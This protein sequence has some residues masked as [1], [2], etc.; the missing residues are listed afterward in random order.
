VPIDPNIISQLNIQPN[1]AQIL[2]QGVALRG[3]MQQQQM[4]DLEMQQQRLALQAQ[5]QLTQAWATPGVITFDPSGNPQVHED[6]LF[7]HLPPTA[8]PGT[9][10]NFAKMKKSLADLQEQQGKVQALHD[11]LNGS[12]GATIK[13]SG[14]DPQVFLQQIRAAQV[15]GSLDSDTANKMAMAAAD[16]GPEAIQHVTDN[17]LIARSAQQR[18]VRAEEE[19]AGARQ[20]TAQTGAVKAATELP[21]IQ[22]DTAIKQAVA[23][24]MKNG[25]T[26]EQQQAAAQRAAELA[27]QRGHLAVAQQR[28]AMDAAAPDLTPQGLDSVAQL[29]HD[30][31]Q[32]VP[33]GMGKKAAE[34]RARIINRSAEMPGPDSLASAKANFTA[35]QASLVA[36]QKQRDAVVAFENTANANLDRFLTT[37]KG[38][39]D[40][41]SP[42][43]N[44]PLRAAAG[45]AF[46]SANKAAF[47]AA[48]LVAQNEIA[49]VTSN[50]NLTGQ[51][52][53]AARR[54]VEA[55]MGPN[56]TLKQ[57]Y[58]VA[59][60]LRADMGARHTALDAQIKAIQDRIKQKP[61]ETAPAGAP[62]ATGTTGLTYQDYL[63]A[64]GG[65]P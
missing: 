40:S 29:F 52:S 62:P 10:E 16:G 49:K 3:Q 60:V 51:L 44:A 57:I 58:S 46:G 27:I 63:K 33:M 64:K 8:I 14:Y 59:Q 38:V 7:S 48:R 23:A 17:L 65:K 30:T 32:M 21:G 12:I 35:N 4:R 6:V 42:M 11:D 2:S 37:A 19:T 5:Q 26:P 41:G 9:L 53:D 43:L 25:L 24:G 45:S 18:K 36:T 50:P 34:L 54:E 55:V 61:G 31:G 28:L 1:S 56:A 20:L 15:A 47:D 22:A 13:A 39:I